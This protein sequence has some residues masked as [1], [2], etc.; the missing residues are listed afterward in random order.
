LL[1]SSPV[2]NLLFTNEQGIRQV[3]SGSGSH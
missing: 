1:Y 3:T 2:P